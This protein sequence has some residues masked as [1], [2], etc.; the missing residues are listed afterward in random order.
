[1]KR[2]E[3]YVL[4]ILAIVPGLIAYSAAAAAPEVGQDAP[5]FTL[6]GLDGAEVTLSSLKGMT[7]IVLLF[8]SCT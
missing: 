5:D 6:K 4:A 8:G 7:P 3:F 1:M 2:K